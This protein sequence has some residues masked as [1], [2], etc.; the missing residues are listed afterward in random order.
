MVNTS[1]MDPGGLA[2]LVTRHLDPSRPRLALDDDRPMQTSSAQ[3]LGILHAWTSPWNTSVGSGH[4][5]V[6]RDGSRQRERS[7]LSGTAS[8]PADAKTGSAALIGSSDTDGWSVGNRSVW[9]DNPARTLQ[10]RSVGSSPPRKRSIVQAHAQPARALDL[11]SGSYAQTP[12]NQVSSHG[13]QSKP[14]HPPLDATSLNFTSSRHND[15]LTNG[16]SNFTFSQADGSGP[17]PEPSVGQWSDAASVHSPGDDR[18][19]MAASDYFGVSSAASSRHGSLPPSRHGEPAPYMAG[20]DLQTRYA[21]PNPRQHSSFSHPNGRLQERSPSMQA[22]SLQ[23]LAGLRLDQELSAGVQSHRP[24][25]SANGFSRSLTPAGA[26]VGYFTD[27]DTE[28]QNTTLYRP[29]N[30]GYFQQGSYTPDS[31]GQLASQEPTAHLRP[32]RLDSLS[33]LNGAAARQSPFYSNTHTPP[34]YE[35]ARFSRPD[36]TL[37]NGQGL[38]LVQEKLVGVQQQQQQQHQH[39]RQQRQQQQQLQSQLQG[40]RHVNQNA[41]HLSPHDFQQFFSTQALANPYLRPQQSYAPSVFSNMPMNGVPMG[42]MPFN[43][44]L[45]NVPLQSVPTLPGGM[46][47]APK[48]PRDRSPQGDLMSQALLDFRN[49]RANRVYQ[50][51]D[52]YGHLVEFCGDQH[53][54]RFIQEKLMSASTEE[55][56]RVFAEIQG[57]SLQLMQDVFGNYVIQKFFELGDQYQKKYLANCMKGQVIK[58]STQMYACR[59]VQTALQHVLTDQQA[60]IVK[61][62]EKDVLN[63]VKDQNGNHVIQKAIELV[64]AEHMQT[65]IDSFRGHVGSLSLHSYGCRVIQRLL[66]YCEPSAKRFILEELHAEGRKIITDNYGNYVAQHVLE[67]GNA[68]DRIKIIELV[69]KD[70]FF[71]SKH[72]FAS[73]VVEKCLTYGD[74]QQRKDIVERIMKQNERGESNVLPLIKDQ[75]GNY[76]IQKLLDDGIL[77]PQDLLEFLTCVKPALQQAKETTGGNAKQIVALENKLL[78]IGDC[79]NP[80]QR[81]SLSST[82]G[83]MPEAPSLVADAQSPHSSDFP[84]GNASTIE[85][86]VHARSTANKPLAAPGSVNVADAE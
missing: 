52:I 11:S 54:S 28:A 36:Q 27:Y 38:V 76:V 57:N 16:F 43:A 74:Y 17:R 46:L 48:G 19:S 83:S 31:H 68:E 64:P 42:G 81:N 8:G 66:E 29:V 1:S 58:L 24:S 30:N 3:P 14:A 34:I 53:G 13:I 56:N 60:D 4:G 26:D 12:R 85:E 69:K 44:F 84:S 45:P 65:I 50:L 80:V 35:N 75:F 20:T 62:L 61:E 79:R 2:S 77:S 33:A 9:G 7:T 37:E 72:K 55:K 6:A 86:P 82:A 49:H 5:S 18:R 21:Q 63:C 39:R 51:R 47:V 71:F 32:S 59:V 78:Q 67:H 10:N 73:N 15:N 41:S 25:I 70:L 23:M 22:D 40:R